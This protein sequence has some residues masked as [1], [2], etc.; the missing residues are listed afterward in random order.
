MRYGNG[1]TG[2]KSALAD[3]IPLA[4]LVTARVGPARAGD[5][6]APIQR[7]TDRA[8]TGLTSVA[9]RADREQLLAGEAV[10][11]PRSR[12][13]VSRDG[14]LPPHGAGRAPRRR[15]DSTWT[16]AAMH[17]CAGGAVLLTVTLSRAGPRGWG[18][19]IRARR[20][21]PVGRRA[22]QPSGLRRASSREPEPM[23]RFDLERTRPTMRQRSAERLP[24]ARQRCARR[25]TERRGQA[26]APR[27]RR[28]PDW[29]GTTSRSTRSPP[30]QGCGARGDR[31]GSSA[32]PLPARHP[33]PEAQA[34]Y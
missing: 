28:T 25:T 3:A 24:G 4:T 13:R 8:A 10:P 23:G 19:S 29:L 1:S 18:P 2:P 33:F 31:E 14:V 20:C 32:G 15:G 26:A 16:P 21:G 22:R 12:L 17:G 11:Q 7:V 30:Q 5:L 9:R 6:G 34:G 27:T